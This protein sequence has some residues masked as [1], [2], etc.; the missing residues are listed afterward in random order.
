MVN[1]MHRTK[2][3]AKARLASFLDLSSAP[4]SIK[5][6]SIVKKKNLGVAK[7]PKT[8]HRIVRCQ[9]KLFPIPGVNDQEEL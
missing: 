3:Q 1:L 9:L 7:I 6:S 5:P 4:Y 2:H 8:M